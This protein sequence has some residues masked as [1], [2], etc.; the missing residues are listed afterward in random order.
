[1]KVQKIEMMT[2]VSGYCKYACALS[3]A[4][5]FWLFYSVATKTLADVLVMLA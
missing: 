2:G 1:M 4:I 3:H 5:A